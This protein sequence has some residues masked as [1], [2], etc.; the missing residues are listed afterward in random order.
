MFPYAKMGILT[1]GCFCRAFILIWTSRD[2]NICFIYGAMTITQYVSS[3]RTILKTVVTDSYIH[4]TD[5]T[6]KS[7][8]K[9]LNRIIQYTQ[10]YINGMYRIRTMLFIF[11]SS[12]Y[13][14]LKLWAIK[15]KEVCICRTEITPSARIAEKSHMEKTKLKQNLV[16][17]IWVTEGGFLSHGAGIAVQ[18]E[19]MMR[20]K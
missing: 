9:T 6:S 19:L 20:N 4:Q 1:D 15:R 12:L 7:A 18:K 3:C 13:T 16:T 2:M 17:G 11:E 14:I 5:I 10:V 8:A